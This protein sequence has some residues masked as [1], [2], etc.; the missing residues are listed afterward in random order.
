MRHVLVKRRQMGE[1]QVRLGNSFFP[2]SNF[3]ARTSKALACVFQNQPP[4]FY[5]VT[6]TGAGFDDSLGPS[7]SRLDLHT[8]SFVLDRVITK[9]TLV[10]LPASAPELKDVGYISSH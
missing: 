8:R 7:L 1:C 10:H 5:I 4:L 6:N 9:R 2:P 3:E